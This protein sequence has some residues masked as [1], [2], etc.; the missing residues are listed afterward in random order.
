MLVDM[1][2]MS[3]IRGDELE[4]DTT[5]LAE[6][7]VLNNLFKGHV[8][9]QLEHR[10]LTKRHHSIYSNEDGDMASARKIERLELQ[11][12]MRA[13]LIDVEVRYRTNLEFEAGASCFV[14]VID[15]RSSTKGA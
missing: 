1:D 7:I 10:G 9:T 11:K 8:K 5:E 4:R 6:K 15:D 2:A 13:S 3:K 12:S 14:L